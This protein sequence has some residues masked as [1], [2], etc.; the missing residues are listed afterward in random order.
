VAHLD[1]NWEGRYFC[2]DEG[3]SFSSTASGKTFELRLGIGGCYADE[4]A[5][6]LNGSVLDCQGVTGTIGQPSAGGEVV[7]DSNY[8]WD[9]KVHYYSVQKHSSS[10]WTRWGSG[11]SYCLPNTVYEVVVNTTY[12]FQPQKIP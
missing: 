4:F 11:T 8:Y 2:R 10:G 3:V 9:N 7:T 12:D 5:A 1:G 6:Y